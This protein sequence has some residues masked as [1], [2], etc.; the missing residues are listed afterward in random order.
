MIG[1]LSVT[2]QYLIKYLA[3]GE[4]SQ[5]KR[6]SNAGGGL[7]GGRSLVMILT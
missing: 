2:Y 1:K 3:H 4:A 7:A 6:S 5:A